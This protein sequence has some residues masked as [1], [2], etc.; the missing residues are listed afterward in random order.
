M[1][2]TCYVKYLCVFLTKLYHPFLLAQAIPCYARASFLKKYDI[3]YFEKKTFRA[4]LITEEDFNFAVRVSN[5]SGLT[6]IIGSTW[7]EFTRVYQLKVGM[8]VFFSIDKRGPE[9]TVSSSH[10]PIIP[11]CMLW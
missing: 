9:T 4:D 5:G 6:T 7:K 3:G 8:E 11:P 10:L 1:T 2:N